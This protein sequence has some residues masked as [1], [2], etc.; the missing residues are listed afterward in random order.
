MNGSASS[1]SV[2]SLINNQI[3]CKCCLRDRRETINGKIIILRNVCAVSESFHLTFGLLL[4][5]EMTPRS[6][7][8]M[9]QL[10]NVL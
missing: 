2:Y 9:K 6:L 7:S 8:C 3:P 10:K 1:F 5:Y 4:A